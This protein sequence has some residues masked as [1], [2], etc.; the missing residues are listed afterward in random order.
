MVR[1]N[2]N[3]KSESWKPTQKQRRERYPAYR[4]T[5]PDKDVFD[6]GED[7]IPVLLPRNARVLVTVWACYGWCGRLLPA[8]EFTKQRVHN[9][10][11]PF[12]YCK[13]CNSARVQQWSKQNPDKVK[14][15]VKRYQEKIKVGGVYRDRYLA[16]R[17]RF[18]RK[19]IGIEQLR[20]KRAAGRRKR[21][22]FFY[23]THVKPKK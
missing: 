4:D 8:W 18:Y 10:Y 15:S 12:H 16:R 17:K 11:R 14:E 20:A 2:R 23:M 22:S 19:H 7:G 13:K 6:I 5:P 3:K 9:K 21:L 1:Q